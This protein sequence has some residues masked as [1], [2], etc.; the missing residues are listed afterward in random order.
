VPPFTE[1]FI[2]DEGD[3]SADQGPAEANF[4]TGRSH[5]FHDQYCPCSRHSKWRNTDASAVI[6]ES[7]TR[8]TPRVSRAVRREGYLTMGLWRSRILMALEAYQQSPAEFYPYSSKY[9]AWLR[10]E[11]T[12]SPQELP[13]WR[14]S[15]IRQGNCAA[16]SERHEKGALPQL[17][18]WLAAIGAPR[19]LLI[20]AN[21][22][23][24]ISI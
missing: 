13:G 21:A 19:N 16:A 17:P 23:R 15:M 10:H 22:D 9:D 8:A 11:S 14:R 4:G 1:H 18:I 24:T 12:L 5:S 3:D 2:D 6:R 20:P 7:N